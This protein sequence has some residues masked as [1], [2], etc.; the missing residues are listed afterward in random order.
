MWVFFSTIWVP[1]ILGMQ[2]HTQDSFSMKWSIDSV[3]CWGTPVLRRHPL[4]SAQCHGTLKPHWPL[5]CVDLRTWG[6]SF[7][8]L[9]DFLEIHMLIHLIQNYSRIISLN[10]TVLPV[11]WWSGSC[12]GPIVTWAVQESSHTVHLLY[13]FMRQIHFHKVPGR[14]QVSQEGLIGVKVQF[15]F[16]R[17]KSKLVIEYNPR[18][19]YVSSQCFDKNHDKPWDLGVTH[20]HLIG[21]LCSNKPM[22]FRGGRNRWLDWVHGSEMTSEKSQPFLIAGEYHRF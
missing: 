3:D 18:V 20:R 8:A 14:Y 13:G 19:R 15:F 9:V 11:F 5:C 10:I 2:C 21:T 22:F 6:E 17:K 16:Q 12:G 1:A 7:G 4:F